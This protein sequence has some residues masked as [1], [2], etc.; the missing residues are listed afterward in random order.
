MAI[1]FGMQFKKRNGLWSLESLPHLIGMNSQIEVAEESLHLLKPQE[2]D[3]LSDGY[4]VVWNNPSPKVYQ[5]RLYLA[6][7]DIAKGQYGIIQRNGIAFHW[8]EQ[9]P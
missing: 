3:R 5:R 8:P 2:G 4:L 7:A 6:E 9:E 1:D